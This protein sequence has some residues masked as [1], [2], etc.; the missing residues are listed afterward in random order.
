MVSLRSAL[1]APATAA[2]SWLLPTTRSAPTFF[3][4]V[5]GCPLALSSVAPSRVATGPVLPRGL[6]PAAAGAAHRA[7]PLPGPDGRPCT[8]LW[9]DKSSVREPENRQ[10]EPALPLGQPHWTP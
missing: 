7:R 6:P 8:S 10:P 4:P 9:C 1:A 2:T 3:R 5:P